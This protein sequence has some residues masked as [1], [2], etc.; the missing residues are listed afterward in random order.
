MPDILHTVT[1]VLPAYPDEQHP[2]SLSG[3]YVI[4]RCG[5]KE[6]EYACWYRVHALAAVVVAVYCSSDY[7]FCAICHEPTSL[8]SGVFG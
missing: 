5:S 6:L 1:E 8:E 4:I 3:G 7:D 2:G